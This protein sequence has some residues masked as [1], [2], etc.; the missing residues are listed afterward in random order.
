MLLGYELRVVVEG[1]QIQTWNGGANENEELITWA[2]RI[3]TL[4][5]YGVSDQRH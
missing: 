4:F 2:S 1:I 3:E 5:D